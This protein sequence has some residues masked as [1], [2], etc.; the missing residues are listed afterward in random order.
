MLRLLLQLW[1]TQKK[2]TFDWKK[3]GFLVYFFLCFM[4]VIGAFLWGF[5]TNFSQILHE[6]ALQSI[7]VP[8]AMSVIPIC[9]MSMFMMK[10]EENG[11]DNAI[12]SRPF[13]KLTW[14]KFIIVSN[15]IDY[16]TAFP[17]ILIT[18]IACFIMPF[19]YALLA[20]VLAYIISTTVALFVTSVR[21]SN[22]YLLTTATWLG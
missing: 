16:W 1:W 17:P 8:L 20:F 11:M 10:I 9:L 3:L 21:L 6:R 2:R 12:K 19:G 15:I 13:T 18:L 22:S 14:G 5:G 7:V 4:A